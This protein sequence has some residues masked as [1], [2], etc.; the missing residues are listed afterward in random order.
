M[1]TSIRIIPAKKRETD[2]ID[3]PG[4]H[5][6]LARQLQ[7]EP[8]VLSTWAIIKFATLQVPK[9]VVLKLAPM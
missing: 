9:F 2:D 7:I 6:S 5:L 3:D 1:A 8:P 4:V